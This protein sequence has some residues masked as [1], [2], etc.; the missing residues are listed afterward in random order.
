MSPD[1]P[2]VPLEAIQG[3]WHLVISFFTVCSGFLTYICIGKP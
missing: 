1:Y 3:G 2:L